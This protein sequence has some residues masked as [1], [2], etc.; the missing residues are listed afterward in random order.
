MNVTELARRLK[1][2]PTKLREIMPQLGF[3]IGQKAIKVDEKTAQAILEKLSDPRVR[4]RFL[5]E[6]K[7]DE[8][9]Y[10]K[11]E[12]EEDDKADKNKEKIIQVPERITVKDL[13]QRMGIE[14]TRLILELMKNGVM[15]SLNQEIDF[16][17][18]SIISEDLGF[19]VEKSEEEAGQVKQI[20]YDKV[21]EIDQATAQP[22][23]PVVVV[24]G[25]VD[26]GKTKL[27]DAI[28]QTNLMEG[29][30]GGITQHIGA[31][32]VEKD[33][34]WLTF[35]DTPGHEAFSAMRSRGA[36]VADV[37]IL[38]VAADDGVQ[39]QTIEA[40][41]HIRQAGLPFIVAINKIDKPEANIDKV[42]GDLAKIDL[43]PEDWGGKT[44]C[45]PISAKQGINI[46][47]LLDT[48]FLVVDMEKDKIVANPEK[49][50]VGTIIE[51]H[52]DKGEGPVATVLVQNGTLKLNDV[53]L[54]GDC[55]GKIRAMKTWR[56][57]SVKEA[58][59][60]TPVR[61]LGLKDVPQVGEILRV[62]EDKKSLRKAVKNNKK[63][64]AVL[65]KQ[66][67]VKSIKKDDKEEKIKPQ[68]KIILKTD[69]LGTAEA[70]SESLAKIN[71]DKVEVVV[72]KQALGNITEK[73]IESA[74]A[75][76]A[77]LI[78][79]HVKL[80][81]EAKKIASARKVSV[82][83]FEVIYDLVDFVQQEIKQL[84]GK[85][86]RIKE[87]GKFKVLKIFR[88]GKQWQI[89]GG[90][91]IEGKLVPHSRALIKHQ[92]EMIG[93]I[94]I[95]EVESGKVKVSEVVEGQQAGV[96]VV[97]NILLNEGDILEVF[98]VEE[99]EA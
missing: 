91:V 84:A 18:A 26:H 10:L 15:A 30:A 79:F 45:V 90:E 22:R 32:Q 52:I 14:V 48:L 82:Q 96:K 50:A 19:K 59:P 37:A 42:K 71:Q 39:P 43:T 63:K 31:Y 80:T 25:H 21:L 85:E 78:G 54:I 87:L 41:A 46:D 53:V 92:H 17:T 77:H 29:E 88:T 94:E 11:R 67:T 1:I 40:I 2:T 93:E 56:G 4:N 89:I 8:L 60:S 97:G 23:P 35:I 95:D 24:M 9:S 3:D 70:I 47:E 68:V 38:I 61:I 73:D 27:L 57:E 66:E 44:I 12:E 6:N 72:I 51:S 58:G 65:T 7:P 13:A 75:L 99:I 98:R 5:K 62:V 76:G 74:E 55:P 49:K 36:Q 69:V 64:T 33:G 81:N 34:R 28:R 16:E 83:I 20:D 86:Q